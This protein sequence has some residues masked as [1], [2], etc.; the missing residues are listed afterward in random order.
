MVHPRRRLCRCKAASRP[1][2]ITVNVVCVFIFLIPSPHPSFLILPCLASTGVCVMAC[3]PAVWLGALH[4][5]TVMRERGRGM[6]GGNGTGAIGNEE[7]S[8]KEVTKS[9][10]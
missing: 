4:A 5:A 9:S 7:G 3:V 6:E 8:P 2:S 10:G 1:P